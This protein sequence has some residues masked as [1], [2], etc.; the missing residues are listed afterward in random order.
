M[1]NPNDFH[2]YLIAERSDRQQIKITDTSLKVAQC[3]HGC[4]DT[5]EK[6]WGKRGSLGAHGCFA[7]ILFDESHCH[8]AREH[9]L[10]C[11]MNFP[12]FLLFFFLLTSGIQITST[13]PA[14]S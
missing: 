14:L 11:I 1:D 4:R 7:Y 5:G 12:V 13:A 10:P 8:T 3:E 2:S 6:G 9:A